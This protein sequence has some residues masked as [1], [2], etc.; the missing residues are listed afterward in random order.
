MLNVFLAISNGAVV[1]SGFC[2]G[3]CSQAIVVYTDNNYG[4]N[5][6]GLYW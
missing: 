3:F 4:D 2:L 6:P 1:I 5:V